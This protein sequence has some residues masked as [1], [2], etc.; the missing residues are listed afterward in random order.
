VQTK[1]PVDADATI[2]EI[3]ARYPDASSVLDRFGI[4]TCC[5]GSVSVS[6]AAGVRGLDLASLLQAIRCTVPR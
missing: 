4:D 1:P 6:E 3:M 5:G 2:N